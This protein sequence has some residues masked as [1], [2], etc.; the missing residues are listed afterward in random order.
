MRLLRSSDGWCLSEFGVSA[1]GRVY[2][3]SFNST[4]FSVNTRVFRGM[5]SWVYYTLGGPV[6]AT[7]VSGCGV[8]ML[9][10]ALGGIY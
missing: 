1:W 7:H 2:P 4:N 6:R 9:K 5:L 3:R 8:A 10:G